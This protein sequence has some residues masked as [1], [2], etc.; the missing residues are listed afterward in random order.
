MK[1]LSLNLAVAFVLL[2][3]GCKI[4]ADSG[5]T[6]DATGEITGK[7]LYQGGAGGDTVRKYRQSKRRGMV[8]PCFAGRE[9]KPAS[10][11]EFP[12]HID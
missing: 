10:G 6:P 2:I 5:T 11:A 7:A 12:G 8:F 4:V 3:T 9:G 1:K